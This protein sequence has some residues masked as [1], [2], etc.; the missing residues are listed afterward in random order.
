MIKLLRNVVVVMAILYFSKPVQPKI[1]QEYV[2]SMLS[3]TGKLASKYIDKDMLKNA[4]NLLDLL[5]PEKH[6]QQ[7]QN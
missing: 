7:K 3:E 1:M 4:Y 6:G 2:D 5:N